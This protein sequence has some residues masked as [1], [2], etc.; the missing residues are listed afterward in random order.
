M[1][2]V[3]TIP[4]AD[5]LMLPKEYDAIWPDGGA[6]TQ[7]KS[8]KGHA[9]HTVSPIDMKFLTED[10]LNVLYKKDFWTINV[11]HDVIQLICIM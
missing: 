3:T 10:Q 2:I 7:A 11:R 6:L 9:P 5:V 8:F 1:K 4:D